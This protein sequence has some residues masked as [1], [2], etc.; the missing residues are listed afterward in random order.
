MWGKLK[1][2]ASWQ[3]T[4][5][6]KGIPVGCREEEEEEEEEGDGGGLKLRQAPLCAQG[7]IIRSPGCGCSCGSLPSLHRALL[8][9]RQELPAPLIFFHSSIWL[10]LV[11]GFTVDLV[12]KLSLYFLFLPFFFVFFLSRNF[13]SDL[14]LDLNGSLVAVSHYTDTELSSKSPPKPGRIGVLAHC[15]KRCCGLHIIYPQHN[16]PSV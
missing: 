16:S 9:E 13:I 7:T 11:W 1:V 5:G 15:A 6:Q 8:P 14:H 3:F 4:A 2:F 12:L 10:E